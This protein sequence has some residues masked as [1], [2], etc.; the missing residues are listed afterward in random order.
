MHYFFS[1]YDEDEKAYVRV[2]IDFEVELD[3]MTRIQIRNF[4]A[5]ELVKFLSKKRK[6]EEKPKN[7]SDPRLDKKE[8]DEDEGNDGSAKRGGQ[9][10]E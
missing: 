6:A 4:V 8:D 7:D 10:R 2:P 5:V 9:G 3:S 1:F